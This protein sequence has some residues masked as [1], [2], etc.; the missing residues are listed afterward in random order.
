MFTF[1]CIF[2]LIS[3]QVV[4]LRG[5]SQSARSATAPKNIFTSPHYISLHFTSLHSPSAQK[6][7]QTNN[8]ESFET[9]ES[10][11]CASAFIPLSTH[12]FTAPP[13]TSTSA[14]NLRLVVCRAGYLTTNTTAACDRS[15]TSFPR[16]RTKTK[17]WHLGTRATVRPLPPRTPAII[18]I[19]RGDQVQVRIRSLSLVL[20][21]P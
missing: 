6:Q 12:A 17:R 3:S 13:S 16:Q 11:D 4:E 19:A 1:G 8:S 5:K 7:E 9:E 2:L 20:P 14:L 10:C 18:P 21:P 15:S